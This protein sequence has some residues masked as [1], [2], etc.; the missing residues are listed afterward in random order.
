MNKL[1][2]SLFFI[3]IFG[4]ANAQGK[5][6][7]KGKAVK[8]DS[9]VTAPV[10]VVPPSDEEIENKLNIEAMG[11]NPKTDF[12]AWKKNDSLRK[13]YKARRMSFYVR[14]KYPH[15]DLKDGK[16]QL[17]YN[18]IYKDTNIKYCVNDSLCKDPEVAKVLFEKVIGDTNFVLVYIDAFSKSKSNQLCN[19]GHETKLTFVRWNIKTGRA[20]WKQK[21]INSCLKTITNMTKSPIVEWNK[22][23]PLLVSYHK[24]SAFIDLKFDPAAPQLGLQS[25]NDNDK[26]E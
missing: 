22:T 11:L 5:S 12:A 20:I 4:F 14:S 6:K 10:S 18:L 2:L 25:A 23:E 15:K 7:T 26:K 1:L 16:I 9:A 21:S 13:I 8:K 19:A 3:S 17:C 24:G